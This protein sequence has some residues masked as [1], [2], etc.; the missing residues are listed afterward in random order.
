MVLLPKMELRGRRHRLHFGRRWPGS[1]E[2]RTRSMLHEHCFELLRDSRRTMC[3][4]I[5]GAVGHIAV[6]HSLLVSHTGW[7][8]AR[9]WDG[10]HFRIEESSHGVVRLC[11][12]FCSAT[13]ASV[14]ALVSF[15]Q[16]WIDGS[17]HV[18]VAKVSGCRALWCGPLVQVRWPLVL[19][20]MQR[21]PLQRWIR[22]PRGS[23]VCLRSA[24][25]AGPARRHR[26][27]CVAG[28]QNF[29]PYVSLSTVRALPWLRKQRGSV[30]WRA[31]ACR[32][33]V[34]VNSGPSRS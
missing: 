28:L 30:A 6:S 25:M 21:V 11:L 34:C 17:A 20:Y 15:L 2:G 4:V 32:A 31:R 8:H 16:P 19:W 1:V 29:R 9:L 23:R 10:I 3:S 22:V 7:H 24:R 26:G 12:P 27:R 33:S 14:G 5:R 13:R 18:V